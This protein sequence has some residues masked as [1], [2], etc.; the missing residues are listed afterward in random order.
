[1]I[2][3]GRD[4]P[5]SYAKARPTLAETTAVS[6]ALKLAGKYGLKIHIC[7]VSTNESLGLID[8]AK[9]LV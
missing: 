1:M 2:S 8:E 6:K 7:H 4:N 9:N 5:E 3:K